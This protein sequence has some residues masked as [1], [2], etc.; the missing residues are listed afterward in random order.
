MKLSLGPL[1]Y[2]WKKSEVEAFYEQ[3]SQ[4]PVEIVYLGE[5]VCA[6]RR[7]LKLDDWASIANQLVQAG[8]QVVL[9]SQTLI[10]S[11]G[12]LKQLMRL[13][14][15]AASQGWQVEAN[16]QSALQLLSEAEVPFVSGPAVNI[17]NPRTLQ[18]LVSL[19]LQRWCFRW[20]CR[21]K[22][23]PICNRQSLRRAC[24]S[25]RKYSLMVICHWPGHRVAL[26]RVIMIYPKIAVVLSVSNT[27]TVC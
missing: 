27:R 1:L 16:D 13:V 24:R 12:D 7:E 14:D 17:Y 6:R 22:P 11:E 15:L 23:W 10:E 19:G 20:S 8:K 4:W 26:P 2:Y 5:T 9:S 21:V 3:V 25:K 18:R